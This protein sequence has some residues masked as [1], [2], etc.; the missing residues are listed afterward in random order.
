MAVL[1]VAATAAVRPA[2]LVAIVG[3]TFAGATASDFVAGL[4]SATDVAL[5]AGLTTGLAAG[6]T[7]FVAGEGLADDMLGDW[8]ADRGHERGYCL[9]TLCFKNGAK[10]RGSYRW[11]IRST[12]VL[13]AG[14]YVSSVELELEEGLV[15]E[16][17]LDDRRIF[18][19]V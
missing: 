18:G 12:C 3:A 1:V 19:I 14:N 16:A 4:G 8:M 7:A 17:C 11:N 9:M 10:K 13:R 5:T 15:R 6:L 2:A